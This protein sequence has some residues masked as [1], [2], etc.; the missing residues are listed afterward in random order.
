MAPAKCG[1]WLKCCPP[2]A[3][4]PSHPCSFLG[5]ATLNAAAQNLA[6]L[7]IGRILL[8]E[9][10]ALSFQLDAVGEWCEAGCVR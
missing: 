2:L 6:M 1:W 8:G 7:I 9:L 5:G 10:L 4:V 3:P